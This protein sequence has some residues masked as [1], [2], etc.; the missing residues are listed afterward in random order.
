[1]PND[2]VTLG[3]RPEHP[4]LDPQG[5]FQGEVIVAER[6][7]SETYLY[8]QLDGGERVTIETRGDT[9]A[10]IHDFVSVQINGGDCHLFDSAGEAI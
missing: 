4:H 1:M 3:V 5:Q 8:V 2:Q 9:P 10:R 6:L 7:G